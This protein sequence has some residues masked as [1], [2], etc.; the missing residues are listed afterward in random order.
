MFEQWPNENALSTDPVLNGFL[1]GVL[2]LYPV[3]RICKRIGLPGVYALPTLIP[4]VG[5]II[6]AS[7]IAHRPWPIEEKQDG[8]DNA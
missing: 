6:T 4:F 1:F 2:I 3:Y 5:W 8:G 7:L